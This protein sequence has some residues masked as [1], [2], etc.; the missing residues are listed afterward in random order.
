M[1]DTE[2]RVLP[3]SKEALRRR[4]PHGSVERR[5]HTS[6]ELHKGSNMKANYLH[7]KLPLLSNGPI[8]GSEHPRYGATECDL[9]PAQAHRDE[10]ASAHKFN[11]IELD[12]QKRQTAV[13][14][15]Q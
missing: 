3:W 2:Q 10:K 11:M 1:Y 6:Q 15:R 13:V 8:L 4:P 7:P 5:Q 9:A 12:A 14:R